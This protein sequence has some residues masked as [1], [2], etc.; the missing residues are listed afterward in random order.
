MHWINSRTDAKPTNHDSQV[1]RIKKAQCDILDQE[2]VGTKNQTRDQRSPRSPIS[3]TRP[4]HEGLFLFIFNL[5]SYRE[6]PM[7][8]SVHL[9]EPTEPKKLLESSVDII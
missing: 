7:T 4:S 5:Y 8:F 2:S 6:L 9:K 3:P 1:N